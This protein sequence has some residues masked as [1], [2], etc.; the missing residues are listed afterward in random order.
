VVVRPGDIIVG[1]EGGVVSVPIENAA[2][3]LKLAEALVKVDNKEKEWFLAGK[4]TKQLIVG[5]WGGDY[6]R[7]FE[8]ADKS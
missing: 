6:R 4:T 2:E 3:V 7:K 5:E 1:S 8:W